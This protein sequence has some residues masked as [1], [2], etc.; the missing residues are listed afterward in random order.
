MTFTGAP[1]PFG[2]ISFPPAAL[3]DIITKIKDNIKRGKSFLDG[4][5]EKFEN[6]QRK[7]LEAVKQKLDDLTKNDFANM[8]L[9]LPDLFA[10]GGT[11]ATA[12]DNLLAVLGK[13]QDAANSN[14]LGMPISQ[15]S[16]LG[17]TLYEATQ[18][19]TNHTNELSGVN[20]EDKVLT[21]QALYGNVVISGATVNIASTNVATANLSKTVYPAANVGTTIIVNS[22][23]K[24]I[25][26]KT[27]TSAGAGSVSVDVLT[28]NT[29]IT[30]ASVATLNL[31][32][33]P[34]AVG[35]TI[36]LAPGMYINVNSEIKQVNTIN[37]LGD[38]LT[39]TQPFRNS[40]TSATLYKEV[41]FVV[42]TAYSAT[43]SDLTVAIKTPNIGN[44]VCLD[45]VITGNGTTF[46]SSLVADNKIYY[47]GKEY[48]VVSVTD[49][50]IVI[51]DAIAAT[52]NE[53]VYKVT[54]ETPVMRIL[55]SNSPG[56]ILAA[57][58]GLDQLTTSMGSNLTEGMT[59][60]YMKSDGTYATIECATPVHVTQSL[61]KPEY[62][63]AVTR[64][65]QGLL[66]D[67]Q[68]DAIRSLSDSE[69]VALL[70]QKT[71][72]IN[73]IKN[74]I[75]DS[76]NQDLAAINAVK[77]LLAGLLKLF[78]ASCSKKKK[79][80]DPENP[81]NTSDEYLNLILKVDP[82][83]QGCSATQSDFID[84]LDTADE[85][86]KGYD[87]NSPNV[88]VPTIAAASPADQFDGDDYTYGLEQQQTAGGSGDVTIDS[89]PD[90]LLP[91]KTVDPCTQPC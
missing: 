34:L 83:T 32:S 2:K 12:R 35:S 8:K 45:N 77:G 61:T 73:A 57:F 43:S 11:V 44:T 90:S 72:E 10:K 76:I 60:R 29:K 75:M 14:F 89:T 39:V 19:F 69:L 64:T 37:S 5:K 86:F 68:N 24:L 52:A 67:L 87:Y 79:G 21:L 16:T 55:P 78:Q 66:D 74:K 17:N 82:L 7:T 33:V 46:T 80:N 9:A 30:T 70:N 54:A 88:A 22:Q 27:Y 1:I 25:V 91:A 20:T 42:N 15:W 63:N 84:T 26:G 62:M 51:D 53:I 85:E 58:D 48:F 38:F 49:T 4:L 3:K 36:T 56:D 65:I 81:D 31:A 40:N 23:E 47:A 6:F 50:Q 71:N 41:G 59:T 28:D 13:A 18:S